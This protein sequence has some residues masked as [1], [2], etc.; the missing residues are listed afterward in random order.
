ME[1]RFDGNSELVAELVTVNGF[2]AA[3]AIKDGA[4]GPRGWV[5][6]PIYLPQLLLLSIQVLSSFST[7]TRII[8][9]QNSGLPWTLPTKGLSL[10]FGNLADAIGDAVGVI[11]LTFICCLLYFQL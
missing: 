8:I 7:L 4:E 3:Y 6:C 11:I 9:L 10:D 1:A 2:K 5:V